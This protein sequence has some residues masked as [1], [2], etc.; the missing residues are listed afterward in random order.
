MLPQVT[1]AIDFVGLIVF[2]L[3]GRVRSY[4]TGWPLIRLFKGRKVWIAKVWQVTARGCWQVQEA[5]T[6]KVMMLRV[7]IQ[8]HQ[9]VWAGRT[10]YTTSPSLPPPSGFKP[11]VFI[12]QL[13]CIFCEQ[14][15]MLECLSLMCVGVLATVLGGYFCPGFIHSS[16]CCSFLASGCSGPHS[17]LLFQNAMTICLYPSFSQPAWLSRAPHRQIKPQGEKTILLPFISQ[18]S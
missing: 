8:L 16:E 2:S 11:L 9:Q 13:I 5:K 15:F 3:L 6:G 17:P 14:H 7:R 12:S 10:R 4:C 1:S 18:L